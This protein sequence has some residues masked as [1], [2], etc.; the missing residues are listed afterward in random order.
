MIK[1]DEQGSKVLR[2]RG[3]ATMTEKLPYRIE[4]WDAERRAVERM[5]G[6]AVTAPLARAIFA[7]ARKEHP[8]R[9]VVL[10]RGQRVIAESD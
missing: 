5:L 1:D 8:E 7:A 3:S 2:W 9:Y 4:L 6:R 10:R